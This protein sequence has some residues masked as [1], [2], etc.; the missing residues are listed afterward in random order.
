MSYHEIKPE[1]PEGVV[2]ISEH[3]RNSKPICNGFYPHEVLLLSYAPR[4]T[5]KQTDYPKFWL[6]KYGI[7]DIH[8]EL[9]KLILR[10]AVKYGTLQDTVNHAT[11]VEI[12][13][14]LAQKGVPQTGTKAKLCER[15]FQNFTEKELNVIFDDRCYQLTELGEEIIKECDWIPYIHNHLIEDLDIWNFSDMMGKASKGVTYRDVLWGYLNQK[16]Q[17]HYI[18]GDFGLYGCTCYTMAQIAAAGGRLETALSLLYL[19]IITNLSRCDNGYRDTPFEIFIMA[20]KTFLYP[21]EKALGKIAPAIIKDM[22]R[23]T[24]KLHMDEQQIRADFAT[25]TEDFS[26]PFMFF[27]RKE[28]ENIMIAEM[29]G[30]YDTLN[31]IYDEANKRFCVQYG[32]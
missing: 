4:Y 21:Y 19:V 14:V 25:E 20:K 1:L 2:P 9:K 32:E 3:I 13:K 24:E 18:K 27:T 11:L 22:C 8:E 23:L 7:A 15:L 31:R 5:T 28:C 12:K 30:D 6:Y 16:S 17:E 29:K 26:L 10:G